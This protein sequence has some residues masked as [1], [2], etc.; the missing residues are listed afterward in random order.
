MEGTRVIKLGVI[1]FPSS[2][3]GTTVPA[4]YGVSESVYDATLRKLFFELLSNNDYTTVIDQAF[5]RLTSEER[6][7]VFAFA[8]AFVAH[9]KVKDEIPAPKKRASS[10]PSKDTDDDD[11]D[12]EV[13]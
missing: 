7:A 3:E 11:D 1:G 6:C 5:P 9:D 10:E 4:H 13:M 12:D 2:G 8:R